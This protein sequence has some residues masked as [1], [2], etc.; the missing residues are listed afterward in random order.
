MRGGKEGRRRVNPWEE[1]AGGNLCLCRTVAVTEA[2]HIRGSCPKAK[3]GTK[4][5]KVSSLREGMGNTR[6]RLE[7]LRGGQRGQAGIKGESQLK[8]KRGGL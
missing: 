8:K 5:L 3:K 4:E 2:A 6:N 7:L 1:K